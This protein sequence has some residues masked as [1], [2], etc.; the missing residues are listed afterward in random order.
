MNYFRLA[1]FDTENIFL[2]LQNKL[3]FQGGKLYWVLWPVY[4]SFTIVIYD[5]NDSSQYFNT[6]ITIVSYAPN[7][8]LALA[9]VIAYDRKWCSKLKRNLR[10]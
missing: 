3:S 5:C 1:A 2:V 4:E 9:S 6:M 10:S 7:L 8:T